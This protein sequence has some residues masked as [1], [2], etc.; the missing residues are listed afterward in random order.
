MENGEGDIEPRIRI[1]TGYMG[2]SSCR[3]PRYSG[4]GVQSPG[5]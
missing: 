2:I 5:G 1:L 4:T 3:V